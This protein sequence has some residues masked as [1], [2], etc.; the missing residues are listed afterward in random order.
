MP[1]PQITSGIPPIPVAITKKNEPE[2]NASMQAGLTKVESSFSFDVPA[3]YLPVKRESSEKKK[4][5]DE[6][7]NDVSIGT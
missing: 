1:Q 6:H 4:L 2:R 7:A 3:S 5:Q